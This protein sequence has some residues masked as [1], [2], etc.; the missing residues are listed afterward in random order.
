MTNMQPLKP[1]HPATNLS[2]KT[3]RFADDG[4]LPN[5]P[6]LPV[7]FY[8][9]VMRENPQHIKQLFH[10]NNWFNSWEDGI[11]PYH[12]YHSNT[13]EVLGVITGTASLQLGGD[14]GMILEVFEGD[15][16]V[17]PAGTAHR[18]LSCTADFLVAGAY[19]GGM[20][21]NTRRELAADRSAALKEINQV[22]LPNT[23]PV[24]GAAG[25]LLTIWEPAN[26]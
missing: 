16:L 13:H 19:P 12:H 8:P 5:N 1:V 9:A 20:S 11:Y 3:Y 15:V 6:Q 26:G 14:L 4:I 7:V 22:P 18:R 17:L 21:Y 24:Y 23:D 25:P 10:I 2:L